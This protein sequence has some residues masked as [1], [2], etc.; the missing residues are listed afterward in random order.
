MSKHTPGPWEARKDDEGVWGVVHD[1]AFLT[2]AF[3]PD[4][5]MV[6]GTEEA[7]ARLIAAAPELLN[8]LVLI[9]EWAQIEK[10]PLRKLEMERIAALIAKAT[11]AQ[12]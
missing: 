8:E 11:G 2:T 1:G 10:A 9:L 3:P 5:G 6:P 4:L 7:N 12:P